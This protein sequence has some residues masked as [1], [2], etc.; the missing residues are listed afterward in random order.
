MEELQEDTFRNS[1]SYSIRG[2]VEQGFFMYGSSL[3]GLLS[4]QYLQNSSITWVP[5]GGLQSIKRF[6]DRIY[7]YRSDNLLASQSYN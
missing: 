3:A 2:K 6:H 1:L 4:P 5:S 7:A